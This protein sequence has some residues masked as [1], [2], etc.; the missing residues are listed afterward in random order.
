MIREYELQED[1][2]VKRTGPII[3]KKGDPFFVDCGVTGST[4]GTDSDPKFPLLRLFR[5]VIFPMTEDLVGD[6]GKFSG[7]IPIV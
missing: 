4:E 5:D 2:S 1:C 3:R 7:Y 6:G